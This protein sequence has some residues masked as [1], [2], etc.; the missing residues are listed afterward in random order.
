[1]PAPTF[2]RP[3][4]GEPPN[5]FV[6]SEDDV[7]ALNAVIS[8][9]YGVANPEDRERAED[10][11]NRAEDALSHSVW[12]ISEDAISVTVGIGQAAVIQDP[13]PGPYDTVTLEV[14]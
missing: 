5:Q 14:A 12:F 4:Q 10:A 2:I 6:S 13:G 7:A 3:I 8:H 11:A 1:M 9:L